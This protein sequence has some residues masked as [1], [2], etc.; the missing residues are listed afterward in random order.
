[1]NDCFARLK[2]PHSRHFCWRFCRVVIGACML[3]WRIGAAFRRSRSSERDEVQGGS[4]SCRAQTQ[5]IIQTPHCRLHS[6][7]TMET[8]V[9]SFFY[10][11][12]PQPQNAPEVRHSSRRSRA[13]DIFL[14]QNSPASTRISYKESGHL[15]TVSQLEH[16]IEKSLL[17]STVTTQLW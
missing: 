9:E 8:W 6:G 14:I 17:D 7:S 3:A 12:P 1:M 4:N 11:E 16:A 2:M 15:A 10:S 5:H 13:I